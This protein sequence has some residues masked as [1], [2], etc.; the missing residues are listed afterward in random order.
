MSD[1]DSDVALAA[2]IARGEADAIAT[3]ERDVA[4]EIEAA[5]KKVDRDR[6]FVAELA[7]QIRIKL[8]VGDG[9]TPPKIA[10]YRGTGPLRA[11]VA[12]ASLRLALNAKRARQPVTNNDDILADVLDREPDP[13]LRHLRALYR[14]ELKDAL[15]AALAALPDRDRALLRMRFVAGLDLAQI[16]KLYRVHESTVSRWVA[17]AAERAGDEA[18][19]RLVAKLAISAATADSVARMVHSQL[20]LSIA[21]LL[22]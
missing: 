19:A 6:S 5:V 17:A 16:A 21:R 9:T 13:E 4:F 1:F 22:G 8:L 7:Q 3:F 12:I 2:R 11:W 18:R 10:S 20:D 15:A 14:T